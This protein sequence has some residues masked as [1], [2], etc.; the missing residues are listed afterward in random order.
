M[1]AV[2]LNAVVVKVLSLGP[3]DFAKIHGCVPD[4]CKCRGSRA[5]KPAFDPGLYLYPWTRLF[6]KVTGTYVKLV[7]KSICDYSLN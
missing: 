4:R 5:M 7:G 1:I 2:K 6:A 3:L